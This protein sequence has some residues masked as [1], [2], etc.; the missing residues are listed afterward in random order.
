MKECSQY[1]FIYDGKEK[2]KS[3]EDIKKKLAQNNSEATVEWDTMKVNK[4]MYKLV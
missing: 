2:K 4:T 3:R 1:P